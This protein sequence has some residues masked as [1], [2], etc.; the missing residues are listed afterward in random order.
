[1]NI[2][3]MHQS[4]RAYETQQ[5]Y[6][7]CNKEPKKED[8]NSRI[9]FKKSNSEQDQLLIKREDYIIT[10][11]KGLYLS[12][13]PRAIRI[14]DPRPGESMFMKLSAPKVVR[15]HKFGREKNL[16]EFLW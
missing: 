3:G 16:H 2:C 5:R 8:L 4:I 10:H 15:F 6:V 1:M 13:L 14:L 9:V 7:S 12:T 11:S